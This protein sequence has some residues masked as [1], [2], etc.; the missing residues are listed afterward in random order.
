MVP[1]K[2]RSAPRGGVWPPAQ[3]LNARRDETCWKRRTPVPR[4]L[5]RQ[6]VLLS[7]RNNHTPYDTRIITIKGM[8]HNS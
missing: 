1:A 5:E 6:A 3:L 8:Y 4:R 7:R 2:P